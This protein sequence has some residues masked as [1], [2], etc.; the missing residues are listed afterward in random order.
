L[1]MRHTSRLTP[2]SESMNEEIKYAVDGVSVGTVIAT[3]AGWLP[4]IAALFTI[5][6]SAVRLWET[7]TVKKLTGRA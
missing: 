1:R 4:E 5:L 7:E 2:D 6:W 3:I